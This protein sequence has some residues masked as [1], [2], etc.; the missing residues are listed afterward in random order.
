LLVSELYTG[1][2]RVE[3]IYYSSRLDD[4]ERRRRRLQQWMEGQLKMRDRDGDMFYDIAVKP[5][6]S[7]KSARNLNHCN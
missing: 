7:G 3:L 6:A 4:W 2:V 5:E 1:D